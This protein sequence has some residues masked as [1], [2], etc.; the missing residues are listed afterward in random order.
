MTS[1][2]IDL[3]FFTRNLGSLLFCGLILTVTFH[4]PFLKIISLLLYYS[5]SSLG[6]RT[7]WIDAL[8]A[9]NSPI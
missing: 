9:L 4:S 7:K 3:E 6:C 8:T 5:A 1:F 2:T